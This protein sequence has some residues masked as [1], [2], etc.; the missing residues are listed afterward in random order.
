MAWQAWQAW[1]GE[2]LVFRG[3]L[4]DGDGFDRFIPFAV[5]TTQYVSILSANS[6]YQLTDQ[7]GF[8]CIK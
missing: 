3:V 8:V 2:S 7:C 1:Q 5:F 6:I 4:F